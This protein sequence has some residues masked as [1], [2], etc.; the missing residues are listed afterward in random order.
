MGKLKEHFH[1]EI[2]VEFKVL[3][4]LFSEPRKPP[5]VLFTTNEGD[6]AIKI[7]KNFLKTYRAYGGEDIYVAIKYKGNELMYLKED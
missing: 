4:G 6:K 7:G 5:E 2:G 1:D 3:I